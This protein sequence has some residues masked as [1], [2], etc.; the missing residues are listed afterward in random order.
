MQG[1]SLWSVGRR[2]AAGI[3]VNRRAV[4]V[5]VV[6]RRSR[7]A[8][9]RV[10][11][12]ESEPLSSGAFDAP[13]AAD[14]PAVTRA[15]STAMAR[16]ARGCPARRMRGVMALPDSGFATAP[17][18]LPD[19]A[20]SA[21][22]TP[23]FEPAV[24]AAAERLTGIAR[25]ALAV[26]WRVEG[27]G[28][29]AGVT[30]SAAEQVHLDTR[31]EAAAAAGIQLIAIDGEPPA[32]LRAIR[33]IAAFET[34][35]DECYLAIWVGDGGVHGW[36]VANDVVAAQM[37]YPA[38]EHADLADALREL[39]RAGAPRCAFVA[40][41]LELLGGERITLADLADL[42][43]C[44]ALPFECAGWCGRPHL[45]DNPLARVPGF[46]VAFGLALRGVF[47]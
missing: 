23:D 34:G 4:R 33:S 16:A 15:L 26:D 17:L 27:A 7:G 10:E 29:D 45:A 24:R 31:I 42:L 9:V 13:D 19:T 1:R 18:V 43:G 8:A 6:S 37:R 39:A 30:I 14:W 5:A 44:I 3:D 36:L 47:E 11:A 35:V 20:L 46:A 38:P 32:A 28:P 41:D 40:G 25:D 2:F 22:S 12:L 21:G